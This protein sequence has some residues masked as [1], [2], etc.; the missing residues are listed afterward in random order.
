MKTHNLLI[1]AGVVAATFTAGS[2]V[3]AP[4]HGGSNYSHVYQTQHVQTMPR[5]GYQHNGGHHHSHHGGG[6]TVVVTQPHHHHHHNHTAGNI[7]LAT[8][9][10]VSAFM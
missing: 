7:I 3:A 5:P 8:A 9:L 10:L 6:H 4:N 1:A 2:A